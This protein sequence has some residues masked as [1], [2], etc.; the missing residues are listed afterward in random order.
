[1]RAS[2]NVERAIAFLE[3]ARLKNP[4]Q[5]LIGVALARAYASHEQPRAAAALMERV[6][7]RGVEDAF[8]EAAELYRQLGEHFHAMS[9]NRHIADSKV[10]LRQRLGIL[11][12]MQDYELVAAMGKDLRRAGLLSDEPV[13]YALA[14][15]YFET[16]SFAEAEELLSTLTQPDLFRKAA[17][18]RQAMARCEREPWT[19]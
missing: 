9:L 17:E 18:L 12:D 2:G 11:I 19:C 16:G 7:L 13:R 3:L 1:M 6:A 14:Y 10:R 4:E 15:A 8:I 5:P